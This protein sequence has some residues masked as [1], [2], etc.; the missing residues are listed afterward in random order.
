[1]IQNDLREIMLIEDSPSDAHLA[2]KALSES[3]FQCNVNHAQDGVEAMAML[4]RQGIYSDC[5][6]PDLIFLDLNMPRKDGRQVLSELK[7]D[8][9][10]SMI[11]V[12]VLTTSADDDDVLHAYNLGSNSYIVKPLDVQAFFAVIEAA[13]QYWFETCRL[14]G[15]QKS[16]QRLLESLLTILRIFSERQRS[17][18]ER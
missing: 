2:L 16:R 17:A 15:Q 4:R 11:P 3:S 10:L 6:R 7:A 8:R 14:P 13:Q 12:I 18:S 1:M 5:P 9:E